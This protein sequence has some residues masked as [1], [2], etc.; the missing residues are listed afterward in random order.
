MAGTTHVAS[1]LPWRSP[2]GSVAARTSTGFGIPLSFDLSCAF[3]IALGAWTFA[4]TILPEAAPGR[5]GLAYWA[6]G[7]ATALLVIV[8]I[9]AHE[10][11]HAITARRARK[12]ST[13]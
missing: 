8:S 11:A 7:A 6:G 10:L 13:C 4:E 9:A 1:R 12:N 2:A 3:G 5:G